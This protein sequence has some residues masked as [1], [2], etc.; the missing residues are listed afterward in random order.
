M[1]TSM[2]SEARQPAASALTD[3]DRSIIVRA[4]E[5]A[6]LRTTAAVR[7]RFAGWGDDPAPA[8]AEAFGTARWLLEEL[9]VITERLGGAR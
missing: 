5:L 7:E 3:H 6:A 9:A 4:R 8:Y 1:A 2:S